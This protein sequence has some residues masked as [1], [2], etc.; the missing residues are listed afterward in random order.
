MQHAMSAN[1]IAPWIA[2][3]R[4]S[5]RVNFAASMRCFAMLGRAKP[6][7]PLSVKPF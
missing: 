4:A 2:R 3:V 6:T 7:A 5:M 1:L